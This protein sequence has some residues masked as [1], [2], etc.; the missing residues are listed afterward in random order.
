[1]KA[2]V[3]LGGCPLLALAARLLLC[4]AEA[5]IAADPIVM[6]Q[7][8]AVGGAS[9]AAFWDRARIVVLSPDKTRRLLTEEFYSACDPE[10]SF[11]GKRILFAGKRQPA[12]SWNVFEMGIDGSGL[13]RITEGR[14]DCRQPR[15]LSTLYTL[16]SDKPWHQIA[17]VGASSSTPSERGLPGSALYSCRLDGAAVLQLT[18]TPSPVM[19]PFLMPD[20]RILFAAFRRLGT[21]Q[22]E[23]LALF[24]MNI[25]GTDFSLFADEEGRPYK[26]MPCIT[27]EGLAVFV[28]PDPT[29]REGAGC[30]SSVKL[31]RN[32]HSY[33]PITEPA[34]GF[35]HSP[36]PLPDGRVL[37]SR[38]LAGNTAS[39]GVY[40][41]DPETGRF[42]LLFDDRAYHDLQARIAA[43]RDEPDGRST[44]VLRRT[45]EIED[46][47][48]L[49]P[50]REQPDP[51]AFPT[52]RLYCLNVYRSSLFK[53]DSL[54][55]GTV[56]RVRVIEGVA[57]PQENLRRRFL[58]E[59]PVADDGSFNIQV[60]ADIPIELQILDADGMALETCG[61][62]WVKNNEPRGC[63]GCHE[64]GE[65]VPENRPA[66]A[67]AQ[68]SI[69]LTL[70]PA[71]RRTAD[72]Q[73]NVLPIVKARCVSCHGSGASL[74]R[75]ADQQD[76][77]AP[78]P[79]PGINRAYVTLLAQPEPAQA[80]H[81]P[82]GRYVTPGQAR[83][84]PLIWRLFG[85]N[86]SR[87]W[88]RIPPGAAVKVMPPAG[89]QPLSEAEK[90]TFVEWIDTGAAWDNR[91]DPAQ[92]RVK[93]RRRE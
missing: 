27:T 76:E 28:E 79:E 2:I 15:Y 69:E 4:P 71:R 86:T 3:F 59:A 70:P 41:L 55:R 61:W 66:K 8:A 33:R 62:I 53:G 67:V 77:A 23:R 48:A 21:G 82:G 80:S 87:P 9:G 45:G 10:V 74:P 43:P 26:T 58:G 25:D 92:S 5:T 46:P 40:Q 22:P 54:P 29:S 57:L 81:P 18:H 51:D 1:M 64:D 17:F 44:S 83:T 73:W 78:A 50:T 16:I 56:K 85:C 6:T 39:Y 37:V 20:G 84:S 13:R 47:D 75:F 88:D 19:D 24:A 38:R 12:D 90:R 32:L 65:S 49:E 11:D 34:D 7:V 31:R 63:I 89:S 30:L 42:Q 36:S 52:G 91:T 68:P 35:F 14:A 93:E 72:F 60:P